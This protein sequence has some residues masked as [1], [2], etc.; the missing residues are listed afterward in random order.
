MLVLMAGGTVVLHDHFDAGE[1]LATVARE[2]ITSA[3]L[4]P[5]MLYQVLDHPDQASTEPA[6]WV[7]SPSPA[8]RW[9][10]PG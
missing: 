1:W 3:T 5:A 8:A 6:R 4:P 2:R 10:R 7:P 9:R